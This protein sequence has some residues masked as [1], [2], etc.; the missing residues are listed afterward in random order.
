V[1]AVAS[2]AG[3][4]GERK[5]QRKSAKRR[6]KEAAAKKAGKAVKEQRTRRGWGGAWRAFISREC[7][8]KQ[9]ADLKELGRLYRAM[10]QA[11]RASL[12]ADGAVATA[13]PRLGGV[14][15]GKRPREQGVAAAREVKRR[16]ALA[17]DAGVDVEAQNADALAIARPLAGALVSWPD[18]VAT[19]NDD[20]RS[21]RMLA[22]D[23]AH[24]VAVEVKQWRGTLGVRSR[25]HL[26][27]SVPP[28]AHV[29]SSVTPECDT[30]SE[31]LYTWAFPAH[32]VVP[33]TMALLKRENPDFVATCKR[34][35]EKNLHSII[36][37]SKQPPIVDPPKGNTKL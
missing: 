37:H 12:V 31:A 6:R 26:A 22:A 8:G 3:F 30:G 25:D 1:Q 16:R 17:I 18:E 24:G 4:R 5:K 2:A 36:I 14:A 23:R 20:A 10:S 27:Q 19:L 21:L 7:R 34:D 11:D 32:V 33:R 9:V 35:W 15:F 29:I 13:S 28:L